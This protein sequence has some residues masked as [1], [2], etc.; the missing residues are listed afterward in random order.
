MQDAHKEPARSLPPLRIQ[1]GPQEPMARP[2]PATG[3]TPIRFTIYPRIECL[4]AHDA[5]DTIPGVDAC[6]HDPAGWLQGPIPGI[7]QRTY[8]LAQRSIR[9][10][11]EPRFWGRLFHSHPCCTILLAQKRTNTRLK[12]SSCSRLTR[13]RLA[14][15]L[16]SIRVSADAPL[17]TISTASNAPRLQ[18]GVE[19]TL[20]EFHTRASNWLSGTLMRPPTF[21]TALISRPKASQ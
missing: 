11:T 12:L 2:G 4:L 1:H 17:S 6:P 9:S 15:P 21:H 10:T 3:A 8:A 19:Q 16:M 7:N 18:P 5:T 13:I 20:R 14:A